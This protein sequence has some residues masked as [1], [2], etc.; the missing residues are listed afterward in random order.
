MAKQ[1]LPQVMTANRLIDGDVV[2]LTADERWSLELC[3]AVVVAPDDDKT[4]WDDAVTRAEDANEIM[5]PYWFDVSHEGG[6]IEPVSQKE[7]I[8]AK[9]P[10]IRTDLGKQAA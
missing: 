5:A 2:Y 6:V 7:R 8:R 4:K 9:G 3:D 10:T 1:K